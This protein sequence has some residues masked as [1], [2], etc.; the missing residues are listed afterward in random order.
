[1]GAGDE[2][3]TP[4]LPGCQSMASWR[5]WIHLDKE[6]SSWTGGPGISSAGLPSGAGVKEGYR[7]GSGHTGHPPP[8]AD[9]RVMT[10]N[11]CDTVSVY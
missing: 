2:C 9:R 10:H 8:S 5:E 11:H 3:S 6:R 7:V 4:T 1:M